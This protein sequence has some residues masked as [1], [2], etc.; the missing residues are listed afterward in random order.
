MFFPEKPGIRSP[1]VKLR[2]TKPKE[3]Y[4]KGKI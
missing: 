2:I 1:D 4:I 3:E